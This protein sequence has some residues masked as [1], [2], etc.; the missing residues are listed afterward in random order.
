MRIV[1]IIGIVIKGL[2]HKCD[3]VFDFDKDCTILIGENGI[4][5]TT[6]IKILKFLLTGEL[7]SVAKYPFDEIIIVDEES[8]YCFTKSDFLISHEDL[9]K[10]FAKKCKN[11]IGIQDLE[12]FKT[13]FDS[14]LDELTKRDLLGVFLEE[15]CNKTSFSSIIRRIIEVYFD[16]ECL[17]QIKPKVTSLYPCYIK[18][19][20][21]ISTF[22]RNIEK[23]VYTNSHIIYGDMVEKI[24]FSAIED[25]I[26]S[27]HLEKDGRIFR[28]GNLSN[29][30]YWGKVIQNVE[31]IN[32]EQC[33]IDLETKKENFVCYD[34]DKMIDKKR[35]INNTFDI[36][37]FIRS[38]YF[39]NS[40]INDINTWAV[41]A[42]EYY[43]NRV[44]NQNYPSV[45]EINKVIDFIDEKV[46]YIHE[47]YI[48]PCIVEE[49][50]YQFDI[51]QIKNKLQ[52]YIQSSKDLIIEEQKKALLL[53][54]YMEIFDELYDCVLIAENYD[55]SI[56]AFQ[57]LIR[58]YI[59][60]K[61]IC[62]TPKGIRVFLQKNIDIDEKDRRYK[63]CVS[64]GV[65]TFNSVVFGD[66]SS[67]IPIEKLSSGECKIIM[68][69]YHAVFSSHQILIMDE[70][71]LS[72]SILWQ[73]RLISDLLDYGEF[74]NIIIATHSPYIARANSLQEYIEYLP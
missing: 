1:D 61:I 26:V 15:L 66:M 2:N 67:E 50:P 54:S 74:K 38:K 16:S 72:I 60:D 73:E 28:K 34:L 24:S 30:K 29:E 44:N 57:D 25:T 4:G 17:F 41:K 56:R 46:V 21:Y 69:A 13:S 7:T 71:E 48:R 5:K 6:A 43:L 19:S 27:Y 70:P 18:S 36:H 59:T 11:F 42:L 3:V 10:D 22:Y 55:N 37:S 31:N 65:E 14:I 12:Y 53:L 39:S 45:E 68:L 20:I 64:G 63:D 9:K 58:Q 33:C 8:K 35:V 32:V 47:N 51:L 23:R 52:C 49:F 62:V 40:Y